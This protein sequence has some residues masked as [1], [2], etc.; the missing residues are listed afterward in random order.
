M[1][2]EWTLAGL[3]VAQGLILSLSAAAVWTSTQ[4]RGAH[5]RQQAYKAGLGVRSS[6]STTLALC[7]SFVL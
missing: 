5:S 4:V 1:V 2:P 7:S 6:A 3:S